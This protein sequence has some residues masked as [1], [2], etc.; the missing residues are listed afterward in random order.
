MAKII[1]AHFADEATTFTVAQGMTVE[2]IVKACDI[3]EAIWSNVVI[4]LNGTEVIRAEWDNVFPTDADVLSVH[5]VPLGSDGKQILRLVAVIAVSLYAP[6]IGAKLAGQ[7]GITSATG[8]TAVKVGVAVVGTLAVNAL[9]PPPTIRPNVPGGSATSNAYFLSG[10]SNRARPYE[11][12][13]VTYGTHKLYANL[14]SAPHIFSAG[15]SSIFQGLYDFGVG[16]Y[17]VSDIAAGTTP[18]DLFKNKSH[19]LHRFEPQPVTAS[20]TSAFKP[21]DLQIYNF[22][23]KAADLSIGLNDVG[24]EGTST[25]HPECKTAVLEISFPSGLTY[26]DD[27]GNNQGTYVKFY[28]SYK[29]S[30]DADFLP[31]PRETK[32][33]AGDDHLQ[34]SGI[35]G[36]GGGPPGPLDPDGDPIYDPQLGAGPLALG[37]GEKTWVRLYFTNGNPAYYGNGYVNGNPERPKESFWWENVDTGEVYQTTNTF[38]GL[39]SDVHDPAKWAY[40]QEPDALEG[41]TPVEPSAAMGTMVQDNPGQYKTGYAF[42]F[43]APNLEG[44]WRLKMDL[45]EWWALPYEEVGNTRIADAQGTFV[46]AEG[47]DGTPLEFDIVKPIIVPANQVFDDQ[48]QESYSFILLYVEGPS[49]DG[50]WTNT[51]VTSMPIFWFKGEFYECR[52]EQLDYV[53]GECVGD[54][55]KTANVQKDAAQL[56]TWIA[57]D[58]RAVMEAETQALIDSGVLYDPRQGSVRMADVMPSIIN[59]NVDS[60]PGSS[61]LE[62]DANGTYFK[63]YGNEATPGIVSIVVPLPEQGSYDFRISRNMD[64]KTASADGEDNESRYVDNAV[65]SRLGSRG[66]PT[67]Q[68]VLN[69][70]HRHTLL[71]VEFEANQSIAGNVQEI[72]GIIRPYLRTLKKDGTFYGPSLYDADGDT[73]YDNPA[74]VALDILTGWTIQNKR[75][76]RFL[77]DH[78]GWLTPDQL[79]LSSFYDFAQHCNKRVTYSTVT[80][81]ATRKRYATNMVVASDAPI[82]ETVQNVLGQCRAQLIINQAGKISI[83]RDEARV[84]PRQMF[85]PS[86]SWDFS[87]SRSFTEIPHCF[88]VQFTSPDLGWQQATVKVYRPG[89]NADGTNGNAVAS[90]FEDL[91]TVGI[92]N[93]HQAQ[94][95]GAYMLAQAVIRSETFTLTTDVENLVCQRG[96][97]VEVAHDAPLMGGRSAVIAGEQ[98]G[99][100]SI[101]E[102]FDGLTADTD[103]YTLRA[104]DGSVIY[105]S[106][107]AI[108]GNEIKI[109]NQYL[110][111]VGCLIVIGPSNRVTE[112]YLIQSIRPKPDLTAEISLVKYD[113]RVYQVDQG[114]FPVWSPNFNQNIATGGTHT[115][116]GVSGSSRLIY[117][118]RQ[119][120]TEAVFS[121]K[122]SPDNESVAGFFIEYQT[123]GG[124]RRRLEYVAGSTRT[125]KHIYESRDTAWGAATVYYITPYSSLGYKGKEGQITLSKR[126]DVTPPTVS[127]FKAEFTSGGNTLLSWDEPTDPD[128]QAYSIYYKPDP[129]NPGYGGEKIAQPAYNRTDW[130]VDGAKEGLYWIIATDTSGNNSDPTADG[131]YAETVYP[132]PSAVIPFD[133]RL[134]DDLNSGELYWKPLIGESID[135]YLIH[136]YQNGIKT[137]F[138]TVPHADVEEQNIYLDNPYVGSYQMNAVNIFGVEGPPSYASQ[139][140]PPLPKVENFRLWV[141]MGSGVLRWYLVDDARVDAYELRYDPSPKADPFSG[142]LASP[143]GST[144]GNTNAF[145]SEKVEGSFYIRARSRFGSAGPWTWTSSTLDSVSIVKSNLTQKLIFIGRFPF[146]EVQINWQVSG[147]TALLDRYSVYF[148]PGEPQEAEVFDEDGYSV[149]PPVLIYEGAEQECTTTVSTTE[150]TGRQYGCFAIQPISIYGTAGVTKYIDF[151]VIKDVTPPLPPERFFVNIVSNTNADLSWL[152][153]QSV[154]VDTYDLRYTPNNSSPRWEAAEHIATVGYNITGYQTNARTGTY[155]IR[156]TDTSGNVS[157]VVMQRTTVA[158]LPDM[159]IVERVEDAP[160][161]EGKKVYFVKDGS[162]LLMQDAPYTGGDDFGAE[163]YREATYYYHERIDLGRIYETRLTA[164]IQAYGQLSGSVMADWNTLAEIDPISGVEESADWD[165]W[166]EYRT[167]TQEDVIADWVNM[168]AQDPISGVV[169]SDWTEWRAFFAADVTA[170]FIDFRI[171]ARAYNKYAEVGVVSGL[172]E[173]DM[174]DRYWTKADVAVAVGGTSV[175]I[176]P[177]FMHLEAVNVT[178]DGSN[179]RV[180]PVIENKKPWGFDI[181]LK[182]LDTGTS[183]SGQVD[184]F[185]SGYGIER[186]EI[187]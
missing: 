74:W 186:P 68:A 117:Q 133:I 148:Y 184:I 118:E 141:E 122:V 31:L 163:P 11:I 164:K 42:Q 8:I 149:R 34:F 84:T 86:N 27:T 138:A 171:V 158:E 64:A 63:V 161:W 165:C 111:D 54:R 140:S 66:I 130:L 103:T 144:D 97:L 135:Y 52:N 21:V 108:S 30:A 46:Y 19:F 107:T 159:N 160:D 96:D 147:D 95:Y 78:C 77:A 176:D 56:Y 109:T 65:W 47:Q 38:N 177:P 83:M 115:A 167:G 55:M 89:Y 153:S 75:A 178:V 150:D 116:Y 43:V 25:T 105:G 113:E 110:A 79:D 99:W 94:L 23:Y 57:Q 12:V 14:A 72:S 166:V 5:V 59:I 22:P 119:P 169:A 48:N 28:A 39:D 183:V 104:K 53:M 172:V 70:Q 126:V 143:Y 50:P 139:A 37:Y 123:S 154:D 187:I 3:P 45:Y 101:S 36:A 15:T 152:A 7:L 9:I 91:D 182:D 49:A 6:T 170:R 173:V 124:P 24:D 121:W 142:D 174:P 134:A 18:L 61:D 128:I 93:S 82:I 29:A 60:W 80:G 92:T 102:S 120:Y 73:A 100:L 2:E 85:T 1:D 17:Q 4:I 168:A 162:R 44:R 131:S 179:Y 175:L 62:E 151:Q 185:C 181:A 76:P 90:V 146:S 156:A 51:P 114:Q 40:N 155:L 10:Q 35:Q 132:T 88:N 87:G 33:Y 137:V 67:D 180:V 16:G 136:R 13:P 58:W 41:F 129:V 106:V 71:E 32:G 127:G 125:F 26:F 81:D 20:A 98:S 112:K 157:D 145:P 69:L